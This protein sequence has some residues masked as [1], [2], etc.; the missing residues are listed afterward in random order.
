MLQPRIQRGVE[1][2]LPAPETSPSCMPQLE[3]VHRSAEWLCAGPWERASAS[4]L[5]PTLRS[6]AKSRAP[7]EGMT[8]S[9]RGWSNVFFP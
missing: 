2:D 3:L 6:P 8:V 5:L 4:M 1:G 7:L 9:Q